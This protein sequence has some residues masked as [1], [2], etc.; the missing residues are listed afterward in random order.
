MDAK[1]ASDVLRGVQRA[2]TARPLYTERQFQTAL[3]HY[4]RLMGWA[5]YHTRYSIGSNPGFPDLVC[6]RAGRVAFCELKTTTGRISAAQAEW[7][8]A[9]AGVGGTVEYHLL[10]PDDAGWQFIEQTFR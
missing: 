3:V 8:E 7:G 2:K 5:T 10:R 9:L 4:L 6:V 1:R